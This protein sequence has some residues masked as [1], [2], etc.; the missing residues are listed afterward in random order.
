MKI[1]RA[2]PALLFVVIL[3]LAGCVWYGP[4]GGYGGWGEHGHGGGGWGEHGG[5]WGEHGGGEGH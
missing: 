2:A 4:G 1:F 3:G 5:G